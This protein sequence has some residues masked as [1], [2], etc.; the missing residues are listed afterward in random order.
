MCFDAFGGP[1]VGSSVGLSWAVG[2]PGGCLGDSGSFLDIGGRSCVGPGAFLGALG[3]LRVERPWG[4]LWVLEGFRAIP[5]VSLGGAWGSW[6]HWE[7]LGRPWSSLGG[8]WKWS[9][10]KDMFRSL[11]FYD[12]WKRSDVSHVVFF[13]IVFAVCSL[14]TSEG[15]VCSKHQMFV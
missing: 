14:Q 15:H 13:L 10:Y 9:W 2:V 5:G 3:S 8:F 12:F 1:C 7:I 11:I 4:P 6:A